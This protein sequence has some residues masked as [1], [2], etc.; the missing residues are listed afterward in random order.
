MEGRLGDPASKIATVSIEQALKTPV[1]Q[2]DHKL[3]TATQAI[4]QEQQRERQPG[5]QQ[6]PHPGGPTIG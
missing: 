5:R 3:H 1:E 2:S 6:A 4:A